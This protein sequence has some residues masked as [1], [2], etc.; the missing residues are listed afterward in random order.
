[1]PWLNW[2]CTNPDKIGCA[3]T[4]RLHSQYN[5]AYGA[6]CHVPR[7][8]SHAAKQKILMKSRVHI[9]TYHLWTE[10]GRLSN[11][12]QRRIMDERRWM[13]MVV[14]TTRWFYKSIQAQQWLA[15]RLASGSRQID[16]VYIEQQRQ[17]SSIP[18]LPS[19]AGICG[20]ENE[21][22]SSC[23]TTHSNTWN[24][25]RHFENTYIKWSICTV[26]ETHFVSWLSLA[27]VL[28]WRIVCLDQILISSGFV[29]HSVLLSRKLI[30]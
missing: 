30:Y 6:W 1:M 12:G 29:S 19:L 27:R 17:L 20:K 22:P 28:T 21:T 18:D 16:F 25:F 15:K 11:D 7:P 5:L 3:G 14:H 10:T 9:Q 23:C 4:I 26:C 2:R 13:C 24:G 8:H